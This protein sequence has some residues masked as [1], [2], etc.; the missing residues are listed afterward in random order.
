M[1]PL[2]QLTAG[3]A[4]LLWAAWLCLSQVDAYGSSRDA[5]AVDDMHA[6]FLA[7]PRPVK[8]LVF[9]QA[10]MSIRFGRDPAERPNLGTNPEQN[11]QILRASPP[12]TLVFW[13]AHTGPQFYAIGPAELER[14]GY[15]RLRA[16]SYELEPLLPHRP[17]LPPYRQ[18]IYLYYKGE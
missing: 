14:A 9:S 5:R 18:E 6:W 15:E 10:Y 3:A 1:P 7:H 4:V 2:L 8:R 13:D 12:G 17:A 16:A 11:A